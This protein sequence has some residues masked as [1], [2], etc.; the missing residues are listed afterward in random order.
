MEFAG[1]ETWLSVRMLQNGVYYFV[2]LP[3]F[4]LV[5]KYTISMFNK[6]VCV[7]MK[8][9]NNTRACEKM[10]KS[11]RHLE[12]RVLPLSCAAVSTTD[13]A[14][15]IIFSKVVYVLGQLLHSTAGTL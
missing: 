4:D 8:I 14:I 10:Q 5:T 12:T 1:I 15:I 2:N 13:G 3:K 11:S 6:P 9:N 7:S